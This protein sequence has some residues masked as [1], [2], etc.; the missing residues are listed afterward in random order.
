MP[1]PAG[2]DVALFDSGGASA[3]LAM[4]AVAAYIGHTE[5]CFG[6]PS[7]AG[8]CGQDDADIAWLDSFVH[9]R[10]IGDYAAGTAGR[11]FGEVSYVAAMTRGDGE[12]YGYTSHGPEEL[13]HEH[14]FVGWASG[15][16]LP[17]LGTDALKVSWGDQRFSIGDGFLIHDGASD[18][19]QRLAYYAGPRKAFKKSPSSA[20]TRARCAARRSCSTAR[21]TRAVPGWRGLTSRMRT[22]RAAPSV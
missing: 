22:R 15:D 2:A 6:V 9:A 17:E 5:I 14:L 1:G 4:N 18:V 13:F 7:G 10:L 8:W 16:A 12:M 20:S 3:R 11:L 19:G 21:R